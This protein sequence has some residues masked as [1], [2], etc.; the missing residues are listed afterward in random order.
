M[1]IYN[2]ET[3]AVDP[4]FYPVVPDSFMRRGVGKKPAFPMPHRFG[5]WPDEVDRPLLSPG[6][7]WSF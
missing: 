5:D 2:M 4:I 7:R 3:D 6:D 1:V